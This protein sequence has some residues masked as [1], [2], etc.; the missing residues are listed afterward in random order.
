M[1]KY[2][3]FGYYLKEL[4]LYIIFIITLIW[5]ASCGDRQTAIKQIGAYTDSI[6]SVNKQLLSIQS[7]SDSIYNS[8]S[9]EYPAK[10]FAFDDESQRRRLA[11]LAKERAAY[12]K[13]NIDLQNYKDTTALKRVQLQIKAYNYTQKIDSLKL[14]LNK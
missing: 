8:Y 7:K 4:I 5:L 3:T 2:K 1:N 11:W 9:N 6:H 13:M 14:E 10:A 12:H